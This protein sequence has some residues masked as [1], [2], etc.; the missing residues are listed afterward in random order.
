MCTPTQVNRARCR[1]AS[2]T[3]SNGLHGFNV[4]GGLPPM[5][6]GIYGFARYLIRRYL[7][8]SLLKM[9]RYL[10]PDDGR[11]ADDAVT[12]P[13]RPSGLGIHQALGVKFHKAS[14]GPSILPA[15]RIPLTHAITLI[16]FG[17][18]CPVVGHCF[19][20]QQSI[21]LPVVLQHRTVD[22]QCLSDVGGRGIGHQGS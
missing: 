17:H 14:S 12:D 22:S 7:C 5:T 21:Q 20:L 3:P 18:V 10:C 19:F 9:C 15:L 4:G 1:S 13:P 6:M 11:S 16:Q 8:A 2:P